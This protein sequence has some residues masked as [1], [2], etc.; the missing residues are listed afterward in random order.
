MNKPH[1]PRTLFRVPAMEIAAR[2]NK[3]QRELQR[4]E[5]DGLL[6]VQRVDLFYF[7]G[8]AQN[9]VLFIPAEGEPLLLVKQYLP[10]AK[11]ESSIKQTVSIRS[12]KDLPGIIF[13]HGLQPSATLA[14][15]LDVLP[16]NDFR[17]YRNLFPECTHVDGSALIHQVRKIKSDWEIAQMRNTADLTRRT[18]DHMR[19]I[20]RPG[21]TELEFAGMFETF[22]RRRGHGAKIRTRHFQTEGYPWHVLSGR[23]GG[24]GF[25]GPKPA[26]GANHWSMRSSVIL[27]VLVGVP[28]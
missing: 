2:I 18:F 8:T 21:L 1:D 23:S 10:R 15:E 28:L 16:V 24:R 19:E 17:F 5:I 6:I 26:A 11:A 25:S 9:G 3:I 14:L 13:D 7:S 4:N 12:I 20:I 22:A 27:D